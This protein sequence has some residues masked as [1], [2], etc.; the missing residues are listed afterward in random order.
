MKSQLRFCWTVFF[1]CFG[2][3]F[4]I[5]GTENPQC[6]WPELFFKNIYRSY[7]EISISDGPSPGFEFWL[8]RV[9]VPPRS[10]CTP[11]PGP[12]QRR[13][14]TI[15]PRAERPSPIPKSDEI[16]QTSPGS[17]NGKGTWCAFS[18]MSLYFPQMEDPNGH[19]KLIFKLNLL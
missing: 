3:P 12:Y 6:F 17:F 11:R 1:C 2:R 16:Y 15:K 13:K 14:K 7:G 8:L 9:P 10:C 19:I 18:F 4:I 5:L